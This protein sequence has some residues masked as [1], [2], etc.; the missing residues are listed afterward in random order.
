MIFQAINLNKLCKEKVFEISAVTIHTRSIKVILCCVYRSP[1]ENPNNF[2]QQLENKLKSIY[3]PT[4]SLVICSDL[5]INH[6]TESSVQQNLESVM[7]TF[8]LTQVV[9][10][11]TRICNNKGTLIDSIF[12]DNAK[13][14]TLSVYPFDSGLSDHVAQILTLEKI[15][16]PLQKYTHTNATRIMYD[17]SIANFQSYLREEA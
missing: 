11:P 16:F 15:I 14:R 10:F 4:V 9:T 5:K 1:S 12:L 17:K 7:K 8:N 13:F 6:F 3:Q 2:L